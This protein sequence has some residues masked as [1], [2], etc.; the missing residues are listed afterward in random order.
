MSITEPFFTIYSLICPFFTKVPDFKCISKSNIPNNEYFDCEYSKDLCLQ[1]NYT[2]IKNQQT[3]LDNWANTFDLY[4]DK[5]KYSP[6]IST[7][8]FLGALIGFLI[9]G[10]LPDKYGRK[11]IF[12]YMLL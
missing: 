7:S 5:E 9:L 10:Y 8:Y 3:S 1:S 6:M 11:I 12:M 2:F 4:C